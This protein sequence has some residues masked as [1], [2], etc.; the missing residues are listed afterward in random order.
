[1]GLNS[2]RLAQGI[3][4]VLTQRIRKERDRLPKLCSTLFVCNVDKTREPVGWQ[5][6]A[7]QSLGFRPTRLM[8]GFLPRGHD[9]RVRLIQLRDRPTGFGVPQF[10]V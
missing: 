10:L 7:L 3:D 6:P 2:A 1:M 9:V 8:F 5:F 4:Y